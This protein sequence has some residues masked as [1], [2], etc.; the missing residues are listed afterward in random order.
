MANATE[1]LAHHT[2]GMAL[3]LPL[4]LKPE[5]E[6]R[7]L[8]VVSFILTKVI[9]SWK[10]FEKV[11]TRLATLG[12]GDEGGSMDDGSCGWSTDGG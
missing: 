6:L 9:F 11:C 4:S 1:T 8:I 3:G 5:F 10:V 2:N 7:D 12:R